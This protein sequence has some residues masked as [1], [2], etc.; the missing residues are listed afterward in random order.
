[1][2]PPQ[3]QM[4]APQGI[5]EIT[6]NCDLVGLICVAA[7]SA[8]WTLA[9]HDV[10][11]LAQKI[12]SKA[13]G[14]TRSLAGTEPSAEAIELAR[15]THKDPRVVELILEESDEIVRQKP[16]VMVVAHK[17]GWVM[18]NAGIDQSNIT[19]GDETVLLLPEDPDRSAAKIRDAIRA[20]T[21]ASVAVVIA[22]SFG[23]AWRRGTTGVALGSA[24][25][26]ALEDWRGRTDRHGR[27]LAHTEIARADEIA[28]AAGLLMGQANEGRP[29]LFMR[30][31]P[32]AL[33]ETS[34]AA[35]LIRPK[36]EDMFR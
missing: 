24:G 6:P 15:Q 19:D 1:L 11:V 31:A 17:R 21:G 7:R 30:G 4:L 16:G 18:A 25:F 20:R 12:V 22:D 35:D 32:I 8:G 23:R 13:E 10:I 33:S 36:A 28:A 3:L 9:D 2:Q 27:V 14:R 26:E 5:G 29:L 34:T